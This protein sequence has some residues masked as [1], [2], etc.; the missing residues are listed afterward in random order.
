MELERVSIAEV[1][2]LLG[3]QTE[4]ILPSVLND[5]HW[6]AGGSNLL[7]GVV[8]QANQN[9]GYTILRRSDSGEY[10]RIASGAGYQGRTEASIALQAA[11]PA[12]PPAGARP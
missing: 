10:H 1:Y 2:E 12:D 4:G 8:L 5:G 7:V 9:W 3:Q 11:V 6:F